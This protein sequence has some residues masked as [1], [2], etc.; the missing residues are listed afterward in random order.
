MAN[1][2]PAPPMVS[3]PKPP[4][5][6]KDVLENDIGGIHGEK[7]GRERDSIP[8]RLGKQAR[9]DRSH[10]DDA[11]RI[12]EG[13]PYN[14]ELFFVD[15]RENARQNFL[16][17]RRILPDKG[18]EIR[19]TKRVLSRASCARAATVRWQFRHLR[20]CPPVKLLSH[21]RRS[22]TLGLSR[23]AMMRPSCPTPGK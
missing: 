14:F 20:Q 7:R 22:A 17:L 5:R 1:M 8:C 21:P 18:G 11:V 3:R 9:L 12:D 15:R 4:S 16:A 10:P 2:S 13:D 6:R 23:S 19:T